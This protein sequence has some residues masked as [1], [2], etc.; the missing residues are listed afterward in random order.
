MKILFVNPP[1]TTCLHVTDTG[2]QY[3][4]ENIGRNFVPL[5]KTP[6]E[7]IAKLSE[8]KNIKKEI[9]L[10]DF[11]WYKNPSF[12][13][14]DLVN[15]VVKKKPDL[16]LTTLGAQ[17]SVDTL[18][19]LT[20]K[21]KERL[22]HVPIIVGGQAV[23]YLQE[24]IFDFCPNINFSLL[25]NADKSLPK[26]IN[27]LLSGKKDFRDIQGLIYN[28]GNKIIKN[29]INEEELVSYS[30]E[31]Y[32]LY[33]NLI[34]DVIETAKV[35]GAYVLASE[36]FSKG[37]PYQ[38]R[39]CAAKRR[40]QEGSIL[41]V[42]SILDYL[43]SLG[44]YRFYIEDLTFGVNLKHRK[45]VLDNLRRFKKHHGKFGFRCVTR[46]D[47]IDKD[48]VNQLLATGCYEVG[49][50]I[51]CNEG[52]VLELMNK[53]V[54][55][56][57]NMRALDILGKSGISFKLF[58]IE[59]YVGSNT[60]TSKRTFELLN[61]LEKR[62]YNYFLQPALSRDIIPSQLRFKEK[63]KKGIL[64]RGTLNQLDFRHDCRRYN[65]DT[66][67]SVRSICLLMLAYPSTE[68][69]KKNKDIN[70]QRR[71][72]CD[73]PFPKGDMNF[74]DLVNLIRKSSSN[75]EEKDSIALDIIHLVDGVY[76]VD[77]I[78]NKIRE[79]YPKLDEKY[80]NNE[81][82]ICLEELRKNGLIDSFGNP[83]LN[84]TIAK[85]IS[86]SSYRLKCK[87]VGSNNLK[88][89]KRK[90]NIL[91]FWDGID[92]RYVYAPL[93]KEVIKIKTC[94]YKNIPKDVFEFL[95]LSKG[96]FSIQEIS[97]RLYKLFR[98]NN[99]FKN[100]RQ[101]KETTK[102]IYQSCKKSKLCY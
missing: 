49:I 69:G 24:K 95:I 26:L 53:G 9:I 80:L 27:N 89:P 84:R 64:K 61:Q 15:L 46:A 60:L 72:L 79:L 42:V 7:V 94:F 12:S 75:S 17:A 55:V 91:L 18:D 74:C 63:E 101:A 6:F 76:A 36:E 83:N 37:C 85:D 59:G 97:K 87:N 11:E 62:R 10:L 22:P 54:S 5:S 98:E 81:V 45:E 56:D 4:E 13:K 21:L 92:Q 82:N 77:E 20:T 47:L 68:L 43:Y 78:K 93:N 90:E 50:G 2:K 25:G 8:I 28:E 31:I 16:I 38:C 100:L 44:V 1:V 70:L 32:R 65:W 33:K 29:E 23:G 14:E 96:V 35:R 3:I 57:K 71:I 30:K 52:G 99:G 41:K 86:I 39:F 19:W 40:Y 66:N 73:V 48:F 34:I 102:E 88:T 67:E 51:E 58:L